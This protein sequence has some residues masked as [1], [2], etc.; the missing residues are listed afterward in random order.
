MPANGVSFLHRMC[1]AFENVMRRKVLGHGAPS[2]ATPLG[3]SEDQVLRALSLDGLGREDG[4]D[5]DEAK[6]E[7]DEGS[8]VLCSLLTSKCD[9][10]RLSLPTACSM[11]ALAL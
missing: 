3:K 4:F 11:P 8:E 2:D 1:V 10:K 6:C 5:Q 7:S 9:L